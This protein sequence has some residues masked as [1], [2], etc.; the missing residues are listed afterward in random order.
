MQLAKE[1]DVVIENMSEGMT[2]QLKIDYEHIR[3]A[4]PRIVYASIKAFGEPS[5]YPTLKGMDIIVQALSGLME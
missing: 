1:C 3:Q 2:A 4:N 5:A